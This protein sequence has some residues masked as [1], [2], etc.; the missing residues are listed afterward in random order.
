MAYKFVFFLSRWMENFFPTLLF[1]RVIEYTAK[2]TWREDETLKNSFISPHFSRYFSERSATWCRFF[3]LFFFF[4]MRWLLQN[5]SLL[6]LWSSLCLSLCDFVTHVNCLTLVHE[7]SHFDNRFEY[8]KNFFLR[9]FSK[10]DSEIEW[11]H[12]LKCSK[13]FENYSLGS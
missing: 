6:S 5:F 2:C 1:T 11:K 9:S 7:I 13:F 4:P 10:H 3:F 12:K 8:T